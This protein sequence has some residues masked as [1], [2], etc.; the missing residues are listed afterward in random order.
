MAVALDIHDRRV[1][2][3]AY[4]LGP[5]VDRFLRRMRTRQM[6]DSGLLDQDV[7]DDLRQAAA[8]MRRAR[9][10]RVWFARHPEPDPWPRFH[11]FRRSTR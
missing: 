5:A 8:A 10:D 7:V 3:E 9:M 6:L 4:Q 2:D 1:F 11:L